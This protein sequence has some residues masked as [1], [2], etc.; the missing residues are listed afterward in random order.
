MQTLSPHVGFRLGGMGVK[1]ERLTGGSFKPGVVIAPQAGLDLQIV[2]QLVLDADIGYDANL[3]PDLGPNAS[4]SGFALNL[5]A[6][7]RF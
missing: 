2:P 6:T 5:G 4:I 7:A 1:S 3:G